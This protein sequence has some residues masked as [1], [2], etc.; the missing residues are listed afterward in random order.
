[1][2]RRRAF[3]LVELLVVIG[4]IATLIAILLPALNNS[5]EQAR[6]IR[7]LSNMRQLVM[8]WQ[9]YATDA[10]GKIC[11]ADTPAMGDPK[12]WHWVTQEGGRDTRES[13][14]AGV[15]FK[16][17]NS[18][19][20]YS[21]PNVSYLRVFSI[22][23]WLNGE[24]PV[25]PDGKLAKHISD[26]KRPHATFVFTEEWDPRGYMIN[27]FMVPPYPATDWVD[28]PAPLHGRVG[29]LAFADGHADR[30]RWTDPRTWTRRGMFGTNTP[31]N[32]DLKDFQAWRGPELVPG[33]S[34]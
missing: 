4:I 2:R 8:A 1:M 28:I 7:C 24:G 29:L 26:V 16:Y 12:E 14:K 21:C 18:Y 31:N 3:T 30:W 11:G 34:N 25:G 10:K 20:I 23:G 6:Q 19:E 5:R 33:R 17:M 32:P 9:M 22:N 15:L 27:S 13:I